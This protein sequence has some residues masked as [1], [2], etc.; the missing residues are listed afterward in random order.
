M[1]RNIDWINLSLAMIWSAGAS[2]NVFKDYN[3]VIIDD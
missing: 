2:K 1:R 3:P